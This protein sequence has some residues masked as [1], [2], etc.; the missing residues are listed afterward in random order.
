MSLL[1]KAFPHGRPLPPARSDRRHHRSVLATVLVSVLAFLAVLLPLAGTAEAAGKAKPGKQ[2]HATHQLHK[3]Q[4]HKKSRRLC[5]R[6][7]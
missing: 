1:L 3:K 7:R 6:D 4:V 2:R 5:T